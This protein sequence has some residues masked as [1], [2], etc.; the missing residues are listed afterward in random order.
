MNRAEFEAAVRREGY[1]IRDGEIKPDEHRKSHAH[2]F[3]ARL[4]VLDGH[5][6][7]VRGDQRETFGPG[8]S[9]TV[10]A[11]TQH[12]EHTGAD[13]ARYLAARRS[14]SSAAAAE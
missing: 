2:D 13:G 6:T 1:D 10:A 8:D 12:E 3:D 14:P 4:F 11:G 9:C 7:L 5:L